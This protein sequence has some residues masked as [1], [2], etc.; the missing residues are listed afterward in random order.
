MRPQASRSY[1]EGE[2]FDQTVDAQE[3]E[4]AV[5]RTTSLEGRHL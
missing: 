5:D 3:I 2:S 1:G 4:L